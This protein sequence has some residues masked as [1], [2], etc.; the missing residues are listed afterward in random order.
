MIK[1]GLLLKRE[2]K[3]DVGSSLTYLTKKIVSVLCRLLP[4]VNVLPQ[5]L[6]KVYSTVY[7][8]AVTRPSTNT[9]QC[10]LTSVIGRELVHST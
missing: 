8:Q 5:N 9:A 10:C 4:G 2:S 6:Q 3:G 1:I 7:S